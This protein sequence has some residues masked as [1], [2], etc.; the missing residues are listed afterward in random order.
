MNQPKVFNLCQKIAIHYRRGGFPRLLGL[1]FQKIFSKFFPIRLDNKITSFFIFIYRKL[2]ISEKQSIY[3]YSF[4]HGEGNYWQKYRSYLAFYG[5]INQRLKADIGYAKQLTGRTFEGNHAIAWSES[6][7]E[8]LTSLITYYIGTGNSSIL[9]AVIKE[10]SDSKNLTHSLID[11]G[12]GTGNCIKILRSMAGEKIDSVGGIDFS[13]PAIEVARR[14]FPDGKFWSNDLLVWA[15]EL[16]IKDIPAGGYDIAYSHLVLQLF[17]ENYLLEL[18]KLIR[19]K[20]IAKVLMISDSYID[21]SDLNSN[22]VS[23]YNPGRHGYVRWDHNHANI[24]VKAGW[25]SNLIADYRSGS[26]VNDSTGFLFFK[27]SV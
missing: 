9:S 21:L 2:P 22:S 16:D 26:N 7:G 6:V 13:S 18:Y 24:L 14:N 19:E 1:F 11:L 23:Q 8:T 10:I 20:S 25:K 12:C 4:N 27:A 15:Q 5:F 3:Y 17:P